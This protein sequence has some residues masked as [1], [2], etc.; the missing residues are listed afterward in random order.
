MF[1]HLK[2][3]FYE[4]LTEHN[5]EFPAAVR[6]GF[7]VMYLIYDELA[8]SYSVKKDFVGSSIFGVKII[9]TCYKGVIDWLTM[10]DLILW[11]QFQER[12]NKG[13]EHEND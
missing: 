5:G 12:F 7:D 11:D 9:P 2:T 4:F 3:D 6:L 13:V 1:E 8:C 10:E